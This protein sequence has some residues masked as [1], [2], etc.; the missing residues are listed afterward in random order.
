MMETIINESTRY[1][2]NSF[3][4]HQW[5]SSRYRWEINLFIWTQLR[6]SFTRPF[7]ISGRHAEDIFGELFKEANG[8]CL[9]MSHLQERVDLLAVK[10]TQLDS[11]V[12]EGRSRSRAFIKTRRKAHVISLTGSE[13]SSER[14]ALL[15]SPSRL[16]L[17]S[18]PAFKE[19]QEGVRMSCW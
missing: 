19:E 6:P 14:R 7:F 16:W 9:R 18:D 12:E 4:S 10:V 15:R 5:L 1:P 11:T 2:F 3:I 8:F 13:F 17:I